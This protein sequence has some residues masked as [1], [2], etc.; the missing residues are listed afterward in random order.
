MNAFNVKW[1][2][3]KSLVYWVQQLPAHEFC[4]SN[5]VALNASEILDTRCVYPDFHSSMRC[6]R[7]SWGWVIE[8]AKYDSVASVQTIETLVSYDGVTAVIVH[9]ERHGDESFAKRSYSRDLFYPVSSIVRLIPCPQES[10]SC[11]IHIS[12]GA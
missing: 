7:F 9:R 2:T 4:Y 11:P 10:L 5:I 12:V 6:T 1:Y 3:N 8:T